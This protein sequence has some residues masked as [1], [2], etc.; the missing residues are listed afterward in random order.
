MTILCQGKIQ[1]FG[2]GRSSPF[3]SKKER[4]EIGVLK[5]RIKK[6]KSK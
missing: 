1:N 4:Q 2:L 5:I 3:K 6:G